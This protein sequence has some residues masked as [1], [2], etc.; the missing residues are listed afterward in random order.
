[1]RRCRTE[2]SVPTT[3]VVLLV[4]IEIPLRPWNVFSGGGGGVG[5]EQATANKTSEIPE[6]QC[7]ACLP[8]WC[9]SGDQGVCS[10]WATF[11]ERGDPLGTNPGA[12]TG[13][14]ELGRSGSPTGHGRHQQ[15]AQPHWGVA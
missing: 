7:K 13:V 11:G 10:P 6:R 14:R 15:A 8:P 5:L 4:E 2:V 12:E 1:M 3:T 9:S